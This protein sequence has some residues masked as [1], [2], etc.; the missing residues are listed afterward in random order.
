MTVALVG[1]LTR[2]KN[3]YKDAARR[4]GIDLRVFSEKQACLSCKIGQADAVIMLTDLVAH[5]S[6]KEVYKLARDN[7]VCL[8]CSH[9]SSLTAVDRC[10]REVKAV[11][12][13]I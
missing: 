2:L 8:V 3:R 9:R 12:N 7:E 4:Q 5:Q 11:H 13:S 1:G 10:L 6:A